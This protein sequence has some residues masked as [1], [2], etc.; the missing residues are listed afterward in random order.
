LALFVNISSCI[1]SNSSG[2][3]CNPRRDINEKSIAYQLVI[4]FLLKYFLYC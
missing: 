2:A 4:D 3:G 1:I